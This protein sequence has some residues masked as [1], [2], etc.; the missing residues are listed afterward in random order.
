[1]TVAILTA[2][3]LLPAVVPESGRFTIRLNG[4]TIGTEEFS[5]RANNKGFV[6]EG[7]TVLMGDP[8]PLI[9]KMELDADLNPTTYEYSH[10]KGSI[11][12]RVEAQS[13]ELTVVE[14]GESSSTDFRFPKGATI[15]DNN[16]FHHYL[17]LLYRVKGADQTF[18]I[19]VP[20]DMRVGQ[21]HVRATASRTYSVEVG[22]VKLEATV[23]PAGRLLRLTVPAANV[24][25][26]R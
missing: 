8:N 6:A 4:Q 21:A 20:Q 17:L 11:R 18:P 26:E 16:F 15:V 3:L 5:I 10:G 1:M 9:S 22:D 12:I 23:D 24:V 25:V 2:L 14:N 13:S 19:F 7:K